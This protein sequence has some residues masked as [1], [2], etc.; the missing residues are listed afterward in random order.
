MD[1]HY[2]KN[3][4]KEANIHSYAVYKG[5]KQKKKN[6][7]SYIGNKEQ[8]NKNVLENDGLRWS[9]YYLLNAYHCIRPRGQQ[10]RAL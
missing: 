10:N 6:I 9:I 7:H 5:Q 1:M 3:K 2:M 4:R 8:K